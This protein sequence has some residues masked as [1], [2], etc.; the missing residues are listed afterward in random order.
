MVWV[1]D[2]SPAAGWGLEFTDQ[3]MTIVANGFI[4]YGMIPVKDATVSMIN[5]G[6]RLAA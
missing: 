6:L 4:I 2:I 5:R 3:W 1:L